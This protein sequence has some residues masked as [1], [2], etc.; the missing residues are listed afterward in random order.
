MHKTIILLVFFVFHQLGFAVPSTLSSA[1][2][3]YLSLPEAWKKAELHSR[4]IEIQRKTTAIALAEYKDAKL[5]LLLPEISIKG[6]AEKA[7]NIPIYEN[8]VFAKPTQHE[9]IH[10]LYHVGAEFYQ[11]LYH[12]NKYRL[13]IQADKTIHQLSEVQQNK[14]VSDIRYKTA[15]LYLDLQRCLIFKNLIVNDIDDQETQ[16]REIKSFHRN[17][18]VL[19]SDVL[20]VEL[21]LSKR[22]MA[23]VTIENDILIASQKLNIIL[24]EP[25][26]RI[27]RPMVPNIE[28]VD[29]HPYLHYLSLALK[30][31]FAYHISEKQTQLSAI[32]LKK[33]KANVRPNIGI[34]GEFYYAN[35][36]IFLA[37]Y[38]PYWY[39][40]GVIGVKVTYPISALYHNIHKVSAAKMEFE[41]EEEAHHNT[42]D[43]VRQEVK[44]AYL[45]YEE[46]LKQIEVS[47]VDVKH[48]EENA[49][50]IKNTYFNQTS[51]ITDLL[52]ADIQLLQARFDLAA[53]LI[54]AQNKYYLLQNIIGVL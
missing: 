16:L 27:I 22:K 17:G 43:M 45:R 48:A 25:D 3:L 18:V 53:A 19:K 54:A 49:R 38:N 29:R 20:R 34:Y 10:T 50:I 32:N 36:Q 7:S 12:G 37:P 8:G 6:T 1:D 2:T 41:K 4:L 23:L 5:E 35:P 44:E 52:D 13:K 33:V 9:V 40:L 31:S 30:H 42:E 39:S 24:G 46:A 21:D 51:L 11:V 28:K 15:S 26:E 14:V 47:E